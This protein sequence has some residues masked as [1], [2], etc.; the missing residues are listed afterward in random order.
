MASAVLAEPSAVGPV[1]LARNVDAALASVVEAVRAP[2]SG[3][4]S[5]DSEDRAFLS[6]L[7]AMRSRVS[8]IEA[9][10]PQRTAEFYLLVDQGSTDLGEL[11][12]AWA[13]TGSRNASITEGIRIASA[14]YRLL[15]SNFGREGV[16][17][18]KGGAL[19]EPERRQFLRLRH[20]QERFAANLQALRDQARQRG[21]AATATE[22]ERFRADAQRIAQASLDLESYLNSLIA[23]SEMRGEW[24]ANAPYVRK[25]APPAQVA[26]ADQTVEDLYVDSDIGQVFTIDLGKAPAGDDEEEPSAIAAVP[27]APATV[28]YLEAGDE[29]EEAPTETVGL[30]GSV[31]LDPAEDEDEVEL[32]AEEADPEDAEPAELEPEEVEPT[33]EETADLPEIEAAPL[34]P[35]APAPAAEPEAKPADPKPSDP[36][37]AEAPATPPPATAPKKPPIG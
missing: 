35:A 22:M 4:S 32:A 6:A 17:H 36:K 15:R 3:I 18:A 1:R 34:A 8:H 2:K 16:R 20:A 23:I 27:V 9:V 25:T 19:S 10:L 21:D 11:R 30:R 29:V 28:E 33:E 24:K 12:V 37:A 7:D 14:S 13:R 5:T 26:E 31:L